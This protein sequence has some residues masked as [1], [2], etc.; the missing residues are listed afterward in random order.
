MTKVLLLLFIYYLN[1]TETLT[2]SCQV[3]IT[4][5][6][7]LPLLP[8]HLCMCRVVESLN[9]K[10]LLMELMNSPDSQVQKQAL[11]AVSKMMISNWEYVGK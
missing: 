6:S 8:I 9:A 10:Y 5:I 3:F 2:E 7:L 11:Q 4:L 1:N